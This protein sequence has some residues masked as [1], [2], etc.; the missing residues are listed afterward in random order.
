MDFKCD[1]AADPSVVAF[2]VRRS[3]ARAS[4]VEC[5]LRNFRKIFCLRRGQ[6]K[7]NTVIL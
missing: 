2:K 4:H 7:H 6:V 1:E 5:L 3:N